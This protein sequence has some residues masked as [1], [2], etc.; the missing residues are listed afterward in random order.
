MSN[1]STQSLINTLQ[2]EHEGL[3]DEISDVERFWFE[4][5]ELGHGPKYDEMACRIHC[6]RERLSRHFADEMRGGY[7]A[8]ALEN[9]PELAPQAE[10]LKRQHS[11]L[12][13]K[14]DGLSERLKSRESAFQNWDEVHREFEQFLKELQ[15][16]EAGEMSIVR[17]ASAQSGDA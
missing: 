16:H 14:L 13:A 6:L 5:K 17:S 1:P 12:L 10:A 9:A 3:F 2:T 11:Q 7:L 15:E 8:G 4:V